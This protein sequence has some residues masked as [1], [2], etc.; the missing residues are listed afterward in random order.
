MKITKRLLAGPRASQD[1]THFIMVQFILEN[2]CPENVKKIFSC[3]HLHSVP[4]P[5]IL[6]EDFLEDKYYRCP[7]KCLHKGNLPQP[8]TSRICLSWW[9]GRRWRRTEDRF[10]TAELK[11]IDCFLHTTCRAVTSSVSWGGAYLHFS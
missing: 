3:T 5:T 6:M 7:L 10:K 2:R 1:S 8:D 11:T 4:L 9:F